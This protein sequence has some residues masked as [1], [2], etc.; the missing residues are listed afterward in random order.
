MALQRQ[1]VADRR[2]KRGQALDLGVELNAA[3][4]PPAL[5]EPEHH[6]AG[7]AEQVAAKVAQLARPLGPRD[8]LVD[9]QH[10][11]RPRHRQPRLLHHLVHIL[12]RH[13]GD[14]EPPQHRLVLL[15]QAI[16]RRRLSGLPA[17]QQ[18]D[19]R[20]RLADHGRLFHVAREDA[21]PVQ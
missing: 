18:L 13:L 15:A 5:V 3:V 7:Y 9:V 16:A 1:L 4:A 12:R 8:S 10:V 19:I 17:A 21:N 11:A 2:L 20:V 6:V 14:E